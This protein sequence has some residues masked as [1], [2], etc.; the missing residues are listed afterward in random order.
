MEERLPPKEKIL[1]RS[2]VRLPCFALSELRMAQPVFVFDGFPSSNSLEFELLR[3]AFFPYNQNLN[4]FA[5]MAFLETDIFAQIVAGTLPC[6]KVYETEEILAFHDINPKAKTHI[7]IIP[8]ENLVTA[9]E[10][11]EH[12]VELFGK[13]FLAAKAIAQQ[14]NL[15]GY[16]L[17]MNVD[18][19]GGQIVPHV[20]LHLLS[21]DFKTAL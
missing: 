13:L 6:Q 2:Q 8:K 7:L 14:E 17:H 21:A 20:H 9:K 18:E 3:F 1:V 10:V 12:N 4:N 5:H 19:K 15:E 11:D 16:K